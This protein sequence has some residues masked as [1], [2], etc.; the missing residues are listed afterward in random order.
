[1]LQKYKC[2]KQ[3]AKDL[4][5]F[6]FVKQILNYYCR[7]RRPRRPVRN[8]QNVGQI[9]SAP[10]NLVSVNCVGTGVLDRPLTQQNLRTVRKA[11][12]YTFRDRLCEI[13]EPDKSK[14]IGNFYLINQIN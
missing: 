9:I 1:M 6:G 4:N 11:G 12:S 14:F 10:T 7:G 5:K 3:K 2:F 13:K 8:V